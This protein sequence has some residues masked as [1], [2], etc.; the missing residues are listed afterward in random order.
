MK[1]QECLPVDIFAE[2]ADIPA[3]VPDQVISKID[4]VIYFCFS[5]IKVS[6][7]KK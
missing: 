3:T 5:R 1:G 7:D 6:I 2:G 4:K